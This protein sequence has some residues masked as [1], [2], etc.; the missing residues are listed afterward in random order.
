MEGSLLGT[1]A[2]MSP[3][4]ARGEVAN[5]DERRDVYSLSVM[6]HELLTL[7]HYLHDKQGVTECIAGVLRDPVLVSESANSPHQRGVPAELWHF[8]EHGVAKSADERFRS[9]TAMIDRFQTIRDGKVPVECGAT[10]M[11]RVGSETMHAVD[12]NPRRLAIVA[13]LMLFLCLAGL[14]TV[15]WWTH[16]ATQ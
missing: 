3:E 2:Y 8:I 4:Q 13:T 9:I 15:V 5:L 7:R 16:L 11:K 14:W 1:P 12:R 6:F 10:F